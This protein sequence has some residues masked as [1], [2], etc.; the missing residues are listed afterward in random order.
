VKERNIRKKGTRA[1]YSYLNA[2]KKKG[3]IIFIF[4]LRLCSALLCSALLCFALLCS[5]LL[6]FALLC[7]ALLCFA[8]LCSA[9][10][11]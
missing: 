5:A 1:F 10:L 7:S 3:K 9:L 2:N 4:S 8:L 11:C 6:C